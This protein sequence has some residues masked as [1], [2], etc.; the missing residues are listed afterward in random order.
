MKM[1]TVL[2]NVIERGWAR[3]ELGLSSTKTLD[4]T[5][6]LKGHPITVLD[7]PIYCWSPDPS[8]ESYCR[9]RVSEHL[10]LKY[11]KVYFDLIWCLGLISPIGSRSGSTPLLSWTQTTRWTLPSS[12]VIHETLDIT[13][14]RPVTYQDLGQR[15]RRLIC[16]WSSCA[17]LMYGLR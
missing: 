7:Q 13:Q 10:H 15:L 9:S 2:R 4:L 1:T 3:T 16:G 12:L 6:S 5:I 11:L 14:T 8:T 17:R